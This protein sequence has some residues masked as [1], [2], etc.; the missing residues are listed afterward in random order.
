MSVLILKK[1][2][3]G[4]IFQILDQRGCDFVFLFAKVVNCMILLLVDDRTNFEG[5]LVLFSFTQFL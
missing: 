1:N 3:L 5:N 2:F 4:T